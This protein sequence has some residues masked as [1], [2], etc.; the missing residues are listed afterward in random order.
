MGGAEGRD[1]V[2]DY[3]VLQRELKFYSENLL[4]RSTLV[5][6]NKMDM[7]DAKENLTCFR[8]ETKTKLLP[9]SAETGEGLDLL[10]TRLLQVVRHEL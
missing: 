8:K 2:D 5:V 6:A 1:P 7:P 4:Q 3:R 9:V 10:K